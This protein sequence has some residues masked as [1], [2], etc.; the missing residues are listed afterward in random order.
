MQT[1]KKRFLAL[2]LSLTLLI[3]MASI[4]VSADAEKGTEEGI[5]ADVLTETSEEPGTWEEPENNKNPGT[6]S[7]PKNGEASEGYEILPDE[8]YVQKAKEP[9]AGVVESG[10]CG[11]ELFWTL[12]E[13]GKLAV[14]GTGAMWDWADFDD[15]F[16]ASVWPWNGMDV[17]TLE[18]KSGVE[19]IG[20]YA[21]YGLKNLRSVI[22]PE[23][24]TKI[25]GWAFAECVGLNCISLP[26]SLTSLGWGVFEGCSSLESIVINSGNA[27]FKTEGS[28]LL[29]K[30]VDNE[31]YA[32]FCLPD[33]ATVNVTANISYISPGVFRDCPKLESITVEKGNRLYFVY[34]DVLYEDD[35]G[36]V[37]LVRCVP[38]KTGSLILYAEIDEIESDA[39]YGCSQI[40][41]IVLPSETDLI[42]PQWDEDRE[43]FYSFFEGI[44]NV[45]AFRFAEDSGNYI[46]EN[47]TIYYVEEG[48][49]WSEKWL[50]LVPS[51]KSGTFVVADGTVVIPFYAFL[52]CKNLT[53]LVIPGSAEDISLAY[54]F[55]E[56]ADFGDIFYLGTEEQWD[57][58]ME[59]NEIVIPEAITVHFN[60]MPADF[61]DITGNGKVNGADVIRL[62][63]YV[64][65]QDQSVEIAAGSGDITGDGVINS[66]DVIRLAKLIKARG[67]A[68]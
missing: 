47:G 48:E 5:S 30:I 4:S 19:T 36:W 28:L 18:I 13:D 6:P 27:V 67:H 68:E 46:V 9:L 55:E 60:E 45:Q 59:W 61:C 7:A 12:D 3:G 38:E 15:G 29:Q 17:Q 31:Y 42:V 24:V 40:T 64:K 66:A 32:I 49:G 51:G 26:A 2:L 43:T 25:A 56:N 52:G 63:Q 44:D 37:S 10:Q 8:Y 34:D 53:S 54:I 39:F 33:A 22:V 23:G 11:Y 62:A 20:P 21:F 14:S 1:R 57:A 16:D 50:E 65:V 35:G 41:E 58:L